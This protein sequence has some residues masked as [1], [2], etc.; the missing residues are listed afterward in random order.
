MPG[1][2]NGPEGWP[3]LKKMLQH[4]L[5]TPEEIKMLASFLFCKLN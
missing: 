4:S 3:L 2:V 5:P 1:T